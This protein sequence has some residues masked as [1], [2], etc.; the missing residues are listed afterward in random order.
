MALIGG[1]LVAS[2]LGSPHCAGMCGPFVCFYSGT[3][4]RPRWWAHVAYNGGRLVSYLALGAIAGAI[5]AGV[6]RM[7]AA[8]GVSRAAAVLAGAVM[9]AWGGAML[10]SAAGVRVPETGAAS[11]ARR[12]IAGAVRALHAQ[13][14]EARGLAL[15]LLT[16]LL[17]CGFLYGFVA[18]AAGTGSWAAGLGVMAVFWAGTLPV[19]AGLG[20]V[21]QR[22][23]G[24]LRRRLPILTAVILIVFG[25]AAVHMALQPRPMHPHRHGPGATHVHHP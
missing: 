9:L 6:D 12:R 24:P 23:L 16:T 8:A 18:V 13:P 25:L 19:M 20:L 1:V 5:G 3:G 17:P 22:A 15:G 2:L 21:A 4:E 11:F 7:G 14:P 10:L